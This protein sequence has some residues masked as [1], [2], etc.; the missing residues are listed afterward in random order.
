[1]DD[2]NTEKV[3]RLEREAAAH[4]AKIERLVA[5]LDHRTH[6]VTPRVLKP[7]AIVAAVAGALALVAFAWRRLR[8]R[9][10]P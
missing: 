4:R 9:F 10:A 7:A 8:R 3:E 6:G 5:E 2:D 1:M